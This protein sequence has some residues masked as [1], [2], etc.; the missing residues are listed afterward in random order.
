MFAADNIST[1]ISFNAN[2]SDEV[3]LAGR[4]TRPLTGFSAGQT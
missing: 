1:P 3:A 2:V 4:A